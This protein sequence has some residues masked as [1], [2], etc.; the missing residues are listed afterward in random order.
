MVW[1][2]SS[3]CRSRGCP[4]RSSVLV[5]GVPGS[6]SW[7]FGTLVWERPLESYLW[8][9]RCCTSAG[10]SEVASRTS[11]VWSR[12]VSRALPLSGHVGG[13]LVPEYCLGVVRSGRADGCQALGLGCSRRKAIVPLPGRVGM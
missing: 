5:G 7:V 1:M 11:L 8:H 10:A 9:I 3:T 13:T 4:T 6:R 2:G 12:S